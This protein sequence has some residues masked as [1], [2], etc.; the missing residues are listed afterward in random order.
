M[1]GDV[2]LGC[3]AG[4]YTNDTAQTAQLLNCEILDRIIEIRPCIFDTR[5]RHTL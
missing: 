1:A 5:R 3:E 4:G 2:A